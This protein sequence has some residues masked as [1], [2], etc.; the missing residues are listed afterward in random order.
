MGGGGFAS[1]SKKK[2]VLMS[3]K[4]GFTFKPPRS[5]NWHIMSHKD[6]PISQKYFAEFNL[7]DPFNQ[8]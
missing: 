7:A 4:A 6:V 3:P 2:F 1:P 5:L 8:L